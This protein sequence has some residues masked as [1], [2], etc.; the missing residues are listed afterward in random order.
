MHRNY[1]ILFALSVSACTIQQENGNDLRLQ[2]PPLLAGKH[3]QTTQQFVTQNGE[4][5]CTTS[6]GEMD[7][8][9]R[10]Q[11]KTV[12]LQVATS[13]SLNPGDRYRIIYDND[14]HETLNGESTFNPRDSQAIVAD[15]MKGRFVY[16]E[17]QERVTELWGGREFERLG[18]KINLSDFKEQFKACK[19]FVT[20]RAHE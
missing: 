13:S 15:L 5:V 9:Q 17:I 4:R 7:V 1:L 3:W 10:A 11:G 8:T 20:S 16:T 19:K 6:A 14:V 18:N 12:T 2:A